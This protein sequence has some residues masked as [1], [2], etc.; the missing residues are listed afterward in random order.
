[1]DAGVFLVPAVDEIAIS[2]ELA[3][4]TRA[5]E[6]SDTHALTNCPTLD[7]RTKRIDPSDD[8]MARHTRPINRK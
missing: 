5:A 3:I 1:M 2:A 6:K 8:F 7:T 4:P